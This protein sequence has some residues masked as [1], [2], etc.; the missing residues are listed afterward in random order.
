MNFYANYRIGRD[1]NK[2]GR[3]HAPSFL[4]IMFFICDV[5]IAMGQSID[6]M[7]TG[8]DRREFEEFLERADSIYSIQEKQV[9]VRGAL[10]LAQNRYP[11]SKNASAGDRIGLIESALNQAGKTMI[12]LSYREIYEYGELFSASK[13]GEVKINWYSKNIDLIPDGFEVF[14]V[15]GSSDIDGPWV[16]GGTDVTY[17]SALDIQGIQR[18]TRFPEQRLT[19]VIHF[20]INE[21]VRVEPIV[22]DCMNGRRSLLDIDKMFN[23]DGSIN[24]KSWEIFHADDR[25][26]S[27]ICG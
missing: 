13:L 3:L 21:P 20:E 7:F 8:G 1:G 25:A 5:G 12:G 18:N 6:D 2:S 16:L 15:M 23:D 24:A 27:L 17:F 9:L 10:A 19:R 14:Q 22:F 11:L 4:A 26:G